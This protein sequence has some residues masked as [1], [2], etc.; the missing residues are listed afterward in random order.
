MDT[1]TISFSEALS[2]WNIQITAMERILAT[3]ELKMMMA[4]MAGQLSHDIDLIMD[5]PTSSL[6]KTT[7]LV[8]LA[9]QIYHGRGYY[10]AYLNYLRKKVFRYCIAHSVPTISVLT[11]I[12]SHF[13]KHKIDRVI[14]PCAGRA[15]WPYIVA[16]WSKIKPENTFAYDINFL[17]EYQ[18]YRNFMEVSNSDGIEG[19]RANCTP[20]TAML[21]VWSPNKSGSVGYAPVPKVEELKETGTEP[22]AAA[23]GDDDDEFDFPYQLARVFTGKVIVFLGEREDF[24]TTSGTKFFSYLERRGFR[25]HRYTGLLRRFD[26]A[27]DEL[28]IFERD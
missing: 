11:T 17:R 23:I 2:R 9:D 15:F 26:M 12:D 10:E 25:K 8:K 6:E 28:F 13:K 24:P 16:S 7:N 4:Q 1:H 27:L 5:S 14:D 21:I 3:P 19:I 22:D 20:S 18:N